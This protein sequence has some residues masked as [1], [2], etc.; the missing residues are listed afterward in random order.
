MMRMAMPAHADYGCLCAWHATV[1]ALLHDLGDSAVD[2][3]VD[4]EASPEHLSRGT[5]RHVDELLIVAEP[6][7]RSLE[8]VRRIAVLAAELP[9]PRVAVV[10]NKLRS[11]RD[12]QAIREF[13]T[14]H[15]LD[16]AGEVPWSDAV[17][18]ADA[19]GTPLLDHAGRDPAVAAI[20]RL[21]PH[22]VQS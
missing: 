9:I 6:Y 1:R 5:A 20:A 14:R 22:P 21:L 2:T 7:Y 16:L 19:A 13:C 15:G 12:G 4:L 17:V 18:A 10:A 3:V 11:A 8:T